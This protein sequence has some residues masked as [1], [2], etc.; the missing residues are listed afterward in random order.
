MGK[1]GGKAL[2]AQS[3]QY[4]LFEAGADT[5]VRPV[6]ELEVPDSDDESIEHASPRAAQNP[7]M[8]LHRHRSPELGDDFQDEEEPS[9]LED[10]RDEDRAGKTKAKEKKPPKPK[11]PRKAKGGYSIGKQVSGNF[12]S[13]KIRSKGQRGRGGYG[14]GRFRRR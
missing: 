12:V 3:N 6:P 11:A 10:A 1:A 14:G 8:Q 2:Q 4:N 9:D 7:Y 13:Y 5:L